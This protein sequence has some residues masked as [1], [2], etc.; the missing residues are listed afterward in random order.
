MRKRQRGRACACLPFADV[1]ERLCVVM[2]PVLLS[3]GGQKR[4]CGARPIGGEDKRTFRIAKY[5]DGLL[6]PKQDKNE[7]TQQQ[8]V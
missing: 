2:L 6:M 3:A 8:Q 1:Q 7:I 5:M 4:D